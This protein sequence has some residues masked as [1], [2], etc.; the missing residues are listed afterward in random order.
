MNSSPNDWLVWLL[1][2]LSGN[3]NHEL[4][5]WASWHGRILVFSWGIV[6]PLGVLIARFFKVLPSQNWPVALDNQV[7]WKTHS[8][9]QGAAVVLALVGVALIWSNA[10]GATDMARWHGYLGWVVTV[11]GAA[12]VGAGFARGTKGGPHDGAMRGDHYDMTPRRKLFERL[13]KPAGYAALLLALAA[14]FTGLVVAD[15]PRWMVVV[16]SLWWLALMAGFVWLQ[17]QGRCMDT[18]QAIWGPDATH[19]GNRIAPVG[20]G[21]KRYTAASFTKQFKKTK[22]AS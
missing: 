17:K 7:W 12:Q 10:A 11:F 22:D 1:L 5:F 20:W 8:L 21:V 4:S 2:P 18:Y 16:I 9:G 6:L 3:P 14:V 19:P 13:H 15:A